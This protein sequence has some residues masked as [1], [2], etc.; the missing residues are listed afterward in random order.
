MKEVDVSEEVWGI[1]VFFC[2]T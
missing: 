2:A 1:Y